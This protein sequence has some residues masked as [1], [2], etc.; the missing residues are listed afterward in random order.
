MR[1]ELRPK[2]I[3]RMSLFISSYIPL[4]LVLAIQSEFKPLWIYAPLAVLGI[5]SLLIVLLLLKIARGVAPV[6]FKVDQFSDKDEDI[7]SYFMVYLIPFIGFDA[8][9]W[10]CAAALLVVFLCLMIIRINSN[11]L[12]INPMLSLLQ[13]RIYEVSDAGGV[14]HTL[15]TEKNLVRGVVLNV[16]H[17]DNLVLL[18]V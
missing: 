18:E 12:Y 1:R 4:I 6:G 13:Y 15:L 5:V 3:T 7:T 10:T 2:L 14:K 9:D 16:V 8:A 11:R 17:V